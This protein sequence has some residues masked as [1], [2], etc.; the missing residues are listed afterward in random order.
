MSD[1]QRLLDGIPLPPGEPIEGKTLVADGWAYRDV[2]RM[3]QDA[4]KLLMGII[5]ADNVELLSFANYGTAVRGQM[6][7][8][9]EGMVNLEAYGNRESGAA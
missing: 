7:I 3:T 8:S 5:G 4:W 9:P 1:W 6:M 2:P